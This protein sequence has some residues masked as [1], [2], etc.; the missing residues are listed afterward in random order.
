MPRIKT[1]SEKINGWKITQKDSAPAAV[2]A[3]A[4][5]RQNVLNYMGAQQ[6]HVFDAFAGQG[7]MY[8]AVWKQAASYVGCDKEVFSMDERT[9]YV[10]DNCRVMRNI[11][12]APYNCFDFDAYGSPW[13]QVYILIKRRLVA[14]GEAVGLIL[15]EGQGMKMDMGG[16]SLA[17]S[18][19]A[20]VSQYMAGMGAEQQ[21]IVDRAVAHTATKM[22]CTIE[23]EWQAI[24]KHSSTIRYIGVV[25]R[26]N[27]A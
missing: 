14:P 27:E 25:M 4:E 9:A 5:I 17:L 18:L 13:E 7:G 20:G 26:G 11:A 6:C 16:M 24:G 23:K 12:L 2:R 1:T 22:H 10:A 8:N 15:T 19:V 3:K 21:R